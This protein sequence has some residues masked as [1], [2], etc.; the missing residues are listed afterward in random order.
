MAK[1]QGQFTIIDYNDAINLTGYISSNLSKT[2]MY[3]PD[4][5]TYNPDWSS[6]NLVLTPSLFLA[7]DGTD[8]IASTE[9]QSVAWYEGSSETAI[10]TGGSYALSGTKNQILTVK[11]N[12]MAGLPGKDFRCVVSY[13]DNTTELTIAHAM[14]ISFSRVVNGS[15]ITALDVTTP[16]GNIFK[17]GSVSSLTAKA[18]LWRGSL[19]D[20][21]NVSYQW[22][23]LNPSITSDQGGGA[24]WEKL[25]N[26]ASKYAGATSDTLTIYAAVVDSY[27]TFKC[28]ATDTDS[29][30]ATFNETFENVAS[31]VDMNDPISV[32]IFSTGGGF[33]KNGEGSSVLTAKVYQAGEEI[34][35]GGNGS[36]TW[37]KYDKDGELDSSWTEKTGKSIT[38]GSADVDAKS[39]FVVDVEV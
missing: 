1:A 8:I 14:S 27:A 3:N 21:T 17:N 9:V 24:G 19:V 35:T 32:Q 23:K 7:G 2:Q 22:Y 34:D 4:N 15:G 38:V 10:T 36:Y 11:G 12:V 20:S 30:S 37:S 33:F 13:K 31:F 5:G 18:Q 28:V 6:T 29:T 39:T 26:A 25:S 16:G